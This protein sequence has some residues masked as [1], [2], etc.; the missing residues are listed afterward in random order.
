[1]CAGAIVACVLAPKLGI[2]GC[3]YGLCALI[4]ADFVCNP[5]EK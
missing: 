1:M 2:M 5:E 3:I 4:A